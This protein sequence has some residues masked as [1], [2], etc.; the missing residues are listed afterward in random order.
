MLNPHRLPLLAPPQPPEAVDDTLG[1]AFEQPAAARA[2]VGR[3]ATGI[4]ETI[5][6]NDGPPHLKS[7]REV[8][9]SLR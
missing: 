1:K 4:V 5:S 2:M 8:Q 7:R 3:W 6:I 9:S